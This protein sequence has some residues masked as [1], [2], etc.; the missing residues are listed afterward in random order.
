MVRVLRQMDG[1]W[2]AGAAAEVYGARGKIEGAL[3]GD[4]NLG[5]TA[6]VQAKALSA[7]GFIGYRDGS[8]GGK[9]GVNLAS[10]EGE[11]GINVA[12]ANVG[13]SGGIGLKLELGLELGKKSRVHFGPFT[14]GFSFGGAKE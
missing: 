7:E 6:G 4:K 3:V 1:K 5:W 8:V 12:G 14:L 10:I 2:M 13:V 11:T 9:V